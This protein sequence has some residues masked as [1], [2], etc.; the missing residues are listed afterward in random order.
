MLLIKCSTMVMEMF[1]ITKPRT[2][3]YVDK[4][5]DENDYESN[6]YDEDERDVIRW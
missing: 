1:T 5:D 2:N 3:D 6:H 4:N